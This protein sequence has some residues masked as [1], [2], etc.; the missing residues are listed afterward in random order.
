[1]K[2]IYY[3]FYCTGIAVYAELFIYYSFFL[4]TTLLS[5]LKIKYSN[6]CKQLAN[7]QMQITV[8]T[9]KTIVF[10]LGKIDGFKC[11]PVYKVNLLVQSKEKE[12][13]WSF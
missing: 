11:I 13:Q 9:P 10:K 3:D 5:Q 1:M 12:N 7:T 4:Y 6:F 2:F 8:G